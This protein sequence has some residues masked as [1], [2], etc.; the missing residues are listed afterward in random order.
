MKK[1]FVIFAVI[2]MVGMFAATTLAAEWA[3][4][5]RAQAGYVRF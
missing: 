5:G 1:L 4:Y 3:F 2:G